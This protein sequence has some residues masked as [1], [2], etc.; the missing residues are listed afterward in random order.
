MDY[1]A[2]DDRRAFGSSGQIDPMFVENAHVAWGKCG[3]PMKCY[4]CKYLNRL[5]MKIPANNGHGNGNGSSNGNGNGNGNRYS[6][7]EDDTMHLMICYPD[8]MVQN[9][10]NFF[11]NRFVNHQKLYTHHTTN[12]ASFMVCDILILADQYVR[13]ST[14]NEN[15]K[16]GDKNGNGHNHH[17]KLPIS[18]ANIHPRS[19]LL[20]KDSIL[21][22]IAA[23]DAPELRQARLLLKR[24]QCHKL[25]KKV[26]EEPIPII[27]DSGNGK[28]I[29][30]KFA[31]QRKLW[32]MSE[33]EIAEDIVK[34][35]QLRGGPQRQLAPEHIIVEKRSIHHGMGSE[36]PVSAMRFL[37][38]TMLSKLRE[39][40]ALLP[41]AHKI[42]EE[43]YECSIPR[44]LLQRTLRLYCRKDDDEDGGDTCNFLKTCYYQ[45]IDNIQKR[46]GMGMDTVGNNYNNNNNNNNNDRMGGGGY[47]SGDEQRQGNNE[48]NMMPAMLSQSPARC[49]NQGYSNDEYAVGAASHSN[50]DSFSR[51]FNGNDSDAQPRARKKRKPLFNNL[52]I[53]YDSPN[54]N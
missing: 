47:D 17:L 7:D 27:H 22:I 15:D 28:D 43:E 8:K 19:Y 52:D 38:K 33:S 39:K 30:F 16:Y 6:P 46:E 42:E 10:M 53:D 23:T 54:E 35:S 50:H 41:I 36:N 18:R 40:P 5:D 2:R 34:C 37:P 11:K 3:R 24:F 29:Q 31:W 25:Y 51:D 4:R 1:L 45:F 32:S 21:D 48:H 20:L 26:A 9:A 44:A 12:A 13:L 14:Q 49:S